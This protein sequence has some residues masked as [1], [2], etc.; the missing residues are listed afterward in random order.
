[1]KQLRNIISVIIL[2]GL[3]LTGCRK[4]D[5]IVPPEVTP[6][7]TAK[8]GSAYNGFYLLNEGNMGSNKST[9]DYYDYTTG[10]YKSNIYA[11]ANPAAVKELGDVGNDL[12]IYLS[13][14]HI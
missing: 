3:A 2:A 10:I 9:L 4:G 1:M 5:R 14:I 12:T 13:L 11:T 7:D 6:V 8:P